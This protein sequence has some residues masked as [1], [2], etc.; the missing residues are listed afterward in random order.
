MRTC[1][2]FQN[3]CSWRESFGIDTQIPHFDDGQFFTAG[4]RMEYECIANPSLEQG[5]SQR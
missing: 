5:T 1:S 4:W 3:S 2:Y